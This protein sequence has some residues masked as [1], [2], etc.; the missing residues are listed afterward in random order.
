[1]SDEHAE[2]RADF[3]TGMLYGG[4]VLAVVIITVLSVFVF[5]MGGHHGTAPTPAPGAARPAAK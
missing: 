1:M 4:I 3:P 2:P 5:G